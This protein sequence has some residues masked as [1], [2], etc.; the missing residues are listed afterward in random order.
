MVL[1][2]WHIFG[3]HTVIWRKRR[4]DIERERGRERENIFYHHHNI[5]TKSISILN[6]LTYTQTCDEWFFLFLILNKLHRR[7]FF[8]LLMVLDISFVLFVHVHKIH[9]F[10]ISKQGY[11]S[12][13]SFETF[14]P[15]I[16]YSLAFAFHIIYIKLL[17]EPCVLI[18]S[19]HFCLLNIPNSII[20]FIIWLHNVDFIAINDYNYLWCG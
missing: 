5:F 4:V 13:L 18:Q 17:T 3:A 12:F 11:I 20:V 16:S 7:E 9:P 2:H 15:Y 8:L 10:L 14:T 6:A 19:I 1:Y